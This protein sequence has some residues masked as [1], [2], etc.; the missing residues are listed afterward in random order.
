MWVIA[1]G[2]VVGFGGGG[3]LSWQL[4][5]TPP[6]EIAALPAA[7]PP[8]A[9]AVPRAP[10]PRPPVAEKPRAQEGAQDAPSAPI[11]PPA[12]VAAVQVPAA[13]PAVAA[14]SPAAL[15]GRGSE[16]MLAAIER[17][18]TVLEPS[19]FS[20]PREIGQEPAG[21]PEA[22]PA[23]AAV[24]PPAAT[25]RQA[26]APTEGQ[27]PTGEPAEETIAAVAPPEV[28]AAPM[29]DAIPEPEPEAPGETLFDT[30][31]SPPGAPKVALSFLQW[32]ADPARRFAFISIDGAPSQRVREGETAAGMTIAAITPKGVQFKREGTVFMIRPRH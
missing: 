15:A 14:P 22:P 16:P 19:P 18:E 25:E 4:A 12:E 7:P 2:A 31:R 29:P 10:A 5:E 28:P 24:R 11:A 27:A 13:A 1:V 17:G 9:I 6:T 3:I 20:P 32:S 26:V 30:G 8:P 23:L 21:E